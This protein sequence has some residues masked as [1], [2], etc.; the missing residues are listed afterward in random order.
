ML[1]RK[2]YIFPALFWA[3]CFLSCSQ[4]KETKLDIL[5]MANINGALENCEC[6]VPSLGGLNYL[7]S[8]IKN[9]RALNNKVLLIDG[10]DCFN[11]YHYKPL[12]AAIGES[13]KQIRPDMLV[14]GEQELFGGVEFFKKHLLHTGSLYLSGNVK[15]ADDLWEKRSRPKL[16]RKV[17]DVTFTFLPYSDSSLFSAYDKMIFD[18][19]AFAQE[20]S[21]KSPMDEI[22]IVIFH[23]TFKALQAFKEKYRQ[24]D[25]IL[26]AHEQSPKFE[27][28]AKP[29]IVGGGSDGERLK[30]IQ[31]KIMNDTISIQANNIDITT[32]IKSSQPIDS[33]INHFHLQTGNNKK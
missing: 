33:I 6:G 17:D 30:K 4:D 12:N 27:L 22:L 28:N 31:I 13:F 18:E 15:I 1:I 24:T 2:K 8:I 9:E 5:F 10:G 21:Q 20:Y 19:R 7:H 32:H 11:S 29:V 25:L 14:L 3:L 26:F 16:S 23:G